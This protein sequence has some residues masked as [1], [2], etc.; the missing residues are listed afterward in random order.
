MY[1]PINPALCLYVRVHLETHT[2]TEIL[3][4]MIIYETSNK[5]D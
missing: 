2:V 3:L 5:M 4:L 1:V